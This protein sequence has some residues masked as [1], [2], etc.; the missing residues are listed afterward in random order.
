MLSKEDVNEKLEKGWI[1]SWS[2]FEV[3]ATKEETTKEAIDKLLDRLEKD[4]RAGVYKKDLSEIKKAIKPM[5]NIDVAYSL[6]AEV[7]F[8]TK[9]FD[10][11]VQ[12]VMEYGPSAIEIY[13]PKNINIPCG[14]A[15]SILN[16][17]SQM[18]HQF[19]AA[20]VGGIVFLKEK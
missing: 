17:I 10:D 7:E 18:M 14:E 9:N 11:L 6:T 19:A 5:K 4:P 15:Q 16:S 12:I 3:L 1:K 2:M 20:G 8:I 13:E